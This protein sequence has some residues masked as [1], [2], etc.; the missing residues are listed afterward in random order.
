MKV[1]TKI[2]AGARNGCGVP[3]QPPAP[4]PRNPYENI[5]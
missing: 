5:P 2:K 4:P 3:G 1:N